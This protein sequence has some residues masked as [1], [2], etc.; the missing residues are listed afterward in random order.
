LSTLQ[1]G[2]PAASGFAIFKGT[3]IFSHACIVLLALEF[4][5]GDLKALNG[6]DSS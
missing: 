5:P 6:G 2:I 1:A 4:C 3:I